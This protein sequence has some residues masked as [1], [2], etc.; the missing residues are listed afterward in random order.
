MQAEQ[1]LMYG[2]LDLEEKSRREIMK[3]I[4]RGEW[5]QERIKDWYAQQELILNRLI[6]ESKAVPD[7]PDKVAIKALLFDV[8]ESHYGDLSKVTQKPD[9]ADAFMRQIGVMI[10]QYRGQS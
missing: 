5:T 3:S 1:F 6:T 10:D 8:L 2:E 7:W 9:R 4:R